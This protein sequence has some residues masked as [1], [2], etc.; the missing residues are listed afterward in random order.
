MGE[1]NRRGFI[2]GAGALLGLGAFHGGGRAF[3]APAGLFSQGTPN[4]TFGILSDIHLSKSGDSF[5][6]EEM[7]RKALEW[8]RDQ[9]VDAVV[10]CGDMAD[11]GLL[12]E[13]EAVARNWRETFPGGMAPDGR[14]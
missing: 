7:F 8:F 13:L 14:A 12:S 9:G 10:V 2:G 6:G 5:A 3:C 4:L 1:L 11:T